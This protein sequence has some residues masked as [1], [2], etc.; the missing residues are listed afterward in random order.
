MPH[1]SPTPELF[2]FGLDVGSD[3]LTLLALSEADYAKASFLDGRLLKPGIQAR[4][5]PCA[6]I[7]SAAAELDL[8]ETCPFIFHI[9]H[10]GSTLLSR[11]LGRHEGVLAL[12]EP[13]IL[14]TLAQLR[15]EPETF[16]RR[17]NDAEFEAHLSTLLKLWSR[18]FRPDQRAVV[19]A[20]SFASE[21][22]AEIL[23][24]AY[25][26]KAIF[27]FVSPQSYLA[28]ILG[29]ENSPREAQMLAPLRARRL[30]RRIGAAPQPATS[31]GELVAMSWASEMTAL[32]AAL[33]AA[34][35][36][37]LWLDFDR[38]LADPPSALG[39]CFQH[40]GIAAS[41]DRIAAIASGPDMR[42]YSKAQE[43][44]YDA[45]LRSDVLTQ[46]WAMHGAEIERGLNWL[47]ISAKAHPVIAAA[48]SLTSKMERVK[49][50]EP[51]S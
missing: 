12:R 11:L 16:P 41:D 34:R 39:A 26:P 17:W 25:R 38:F 19:K 14:R 15:A 10:V 4:T 21:L 7:Q 23:G 9:G 28:T 27:M 24:R 6:S 50:I 44:N 22:A 49:G 45:K 36:R 51:S 35:E 48:I 47:E 33:P 8:M 46:A 30:H 32:A 3:S 43:Y 1:L 42:T 37:I 18:T 31:M 20:T 5:M 13:A 40:L 2:P 29:A